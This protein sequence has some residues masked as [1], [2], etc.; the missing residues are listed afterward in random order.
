MISASLAILT[1]SMDIT[2]STASLQQSKILLSSLL[3]K[4][5]SLL[6]AIRATTL[7]V[8]DVT[9]TSMV[10]ATS[11]STAQTGISAQVALSTLASSILVTDLSPSTSLSMTSPLCLDHTAARL[12]TTASTVM[13]L[14]ATKTMVARHILRVTDT[15]ALS[16]MIPTSVPAARLAL[17]IHTTE[18]IL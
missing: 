16:A 8:M 11:A 7:S 14:F 6:A 18:L 12:A 1:T 17:Q 2:Q 15:S 13:A 10:F 9:S 3:L 4:P 5:S